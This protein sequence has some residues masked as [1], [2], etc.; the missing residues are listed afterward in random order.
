MIK[1]LIKRNKQED[2]MEFEKDTELKFCGEE[3]IV[4]PHCEH[5]HEDDY[6]ELDSNERE[7]QC[8]NCEKFFKVI[9]DFSVDFTTYRQKLSVDKPVQRSDKNK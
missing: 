8:E 2:K 3:N 1:A 9:R 4:C 7:D 5:E 6:W